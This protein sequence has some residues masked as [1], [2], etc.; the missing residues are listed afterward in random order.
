[1]TS[2]AERIRQVSAFLVDDAQRPSAPGSA[3]RSP[4]SPPVATRP[5]LDG[6]AVPG[7]VPSNAK[8]MKGKAKRPLTSRLEIRRSIGRNSSRMI[9]GNAGRRGFW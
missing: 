7:Q 2:V 3:S 6:I 8:M 4:Q 1:M 9:N 5:H